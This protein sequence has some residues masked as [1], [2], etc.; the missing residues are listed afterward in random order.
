MTEYA[1]LHWMLE[2]DEPITERDI[3]EI[4]VFLRD[5]WE[6]TGSGEYHAWPPEDE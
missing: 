4:E 2:F 5:E 1:E 3:A 6:P